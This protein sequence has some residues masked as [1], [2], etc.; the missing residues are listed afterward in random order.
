MSDPYN[1]E[2]IQR[3]KAAKN[4]AKEHEERDRGYTSW[5]PWSVSDLVQWDAVGYQVGPCLVDPGLATQAWLGAQYHGIWASPLF[6]L[7]PDLRNSKASLSHQ[8]NGIPIWNREARLNIAVTSGTI[9]TFVAPPVT[10]GD[11]NQ[12]LTDNL[13]VYL[14]EVVHPYKAEFTPA[15]TTATDPAQNQT[16][17]LTT[18]ARPLQPNINN[19][20][21]ALAW[22]GAIAKAPNVAGGFPLAWAMTLSPPNSVGSVG[23]Q[24][25]VRYWRV[26]LT[27]QKMAFLDSSSTVAVPVPYAAPDILV[28]AAYY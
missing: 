8:T 5:P 16:V 21:V 2:D 7:R 6:D 4:V 26:I 25:G 13:Q 28:E 3:G 18:A 19:N 24:S 27:F 17:I 9:L 12:F 11:E 15:P 23:R 22:G 14:S 10:A 1:Y 20:G